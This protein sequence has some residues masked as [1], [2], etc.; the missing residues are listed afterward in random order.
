MNKT[1]KISALRNKGIEIDN[2]ASAEQVNQLY[3]THCV[4]NGSDTAEV[5]ETTNPANTAVVA[6]KLVVLGNELK[7]VA[8]TDTSVSDYIKTKKAKEFPDFI[9]ECLDGHYTTTGQCAF[10]HWL[11]ADG[12]DRIFALPVLR[13]DDGTLFA[14]A[15]WD[16]CPRMPICPA[17]GDEFTPSWIVKTQFTSQSQRDQLALSI[18][19]GTEVWI[20]SVRGYWHN[21]LKQPKRQYL[22][23]YCEDHA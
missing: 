21:P 18:P 13:G 4:K 14:V 12:V 9:G 3:A 16:L 23:K 1:Q 10:A 15:T 20:K 7:L 5:S 11:D 17:D 22:V 19:S 8:Q 6:E 2:S